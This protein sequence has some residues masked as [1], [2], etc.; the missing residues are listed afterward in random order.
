MDTNIQDNFLDIVFPILGSKEANITTPPDLNKL[1]FYTNMNNLNSIKSKIDAIGEK[2]WDYLKKK[3]N[4]FECVTTNGGLANH[5]PISRAYFKMLE[6]IQLFGDKIFELDK[7]FTTLH[8]AEGPG[9][10][11]ECINNKLEDMKYTDYKM[12]GMTLMKEDKC[13]PS[14]KKSSYFLEHNKNIEILCGKDGTGDLYNLDNIYDIM[15]RIKTKATIITGDG[16]FDFSTDFNQQESMSFPLLYCQSLAA[17]LCQ[18]PG[19]MFIL[20]FFDTY[21]TKTLQLIYLLHK[22]YKNVYFVKPYTSRP[23][24]S[25]KYLVCI[26]FLDNISREE[27][28]K[29]LLDIPKIGST[30]NNN[31]EISKYNCEDIEFYNS[32]NNVNNI[33]YER[34]REFINNTLDL[35]KD[36]KLEECKETLFKRQILTSSEWCRRYGL[37]INYQSKF[38][39]SYSKINFNCE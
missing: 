27:I 37:K 18:K 30:M 39:N 15:D 31:L 7:P 24:N 17:L 10:F 2:D 20:K 1:N 34:Q 36:N 35:Y 3:S 22:C 11:M 5:N 32:I 6:I 28:H 12:Y 29:L 21:Q 8:L 13:V 19:G 38:L 14:W 25:E 23:A 9:G 4:P 33:T 26:D 16:G